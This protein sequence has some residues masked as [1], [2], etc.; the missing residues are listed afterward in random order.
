MV[1][2][3]NHGFMRRKSCLSNLT[4]DKMTSLMGERAVN[5]VYL[6]LT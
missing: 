6:E 5:V 3:N 1:N 4:D 2:E